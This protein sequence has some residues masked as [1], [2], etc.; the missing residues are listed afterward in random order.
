MSFY[1]TKEI[2]PWL[3]SIRD[4]QNVF[5]YLAVGKEKALLFD[6]VYGIGNLPS[7]IKE[8]TDKPVDVVLGHGHLDH[9]NGACQFDEAWLNE[10]DFEL[11]RLHTSEEYR[12]TALNQIKEYGI[13]LPDDFNI[14][15]Y[16]KGGTGNL[17]KLDNGKIFDLGGLHI[18][19]IGMGGHTAGSIGIL[20]KEHKVLLTSD[21][22][23]PQVWMFKIE[24]LSVKEY[25]AML[26]RVV[27]LDFDNFITGHTDEIM[28]KSDFYKY[29][30][31]A[32]NL[33]VEKSVPFKYHPELKGLL[34]SEDGVEIVFSE[35]K[36]K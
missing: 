36:L 28:P 30:K 6:T 26:E 4:P 8:I 19:I 2:Y 5:C 34:Y 13:V 1:K 12:R 9:A 20:V 14:D 15:E 17:K 25:I 18:E 22:A 7:A 24:S 33:S 23:T 35:A 32:R 27:K 31:A 11:C 21:S 10:A 29:I 3:Y 16:L